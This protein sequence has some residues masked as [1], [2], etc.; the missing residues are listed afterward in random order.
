MNE[1]VMNDDEKEIYSQ[2]IRVDDKI[3]INRQETNNSVS[4]TKGRSTIVKRS[5][6]LTIPKNMF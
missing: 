1:W 3:T 5:Y 6:L 2:A 4:D